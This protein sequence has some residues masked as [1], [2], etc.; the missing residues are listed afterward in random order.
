MP[1]NLYL[2]HLN[3]TILM[4]NVI[5][6]HYALVGTEF[7]PEICPAKCGQ[8]S[9]HRYPS[10]KSRL[11]PVCFLWSKNKVL[12]ENGYNRLINIYNLK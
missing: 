6:L 11:N 4:K 3:H 7:L 9:P 2:D 5:T 1:K 12:Q 8:S 10:K